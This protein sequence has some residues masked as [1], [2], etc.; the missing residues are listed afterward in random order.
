MLEE[1]C[2]AVEGAAK[3]GGVYPEVLFSVA[4]YW[5][6]LYEARTRH[7]ARTG[8]GRRGLHQDG[9]DL[10]LPPPPLSLEQQIAQPP[11]GPPMDSK[12]PIH[13]PVPVN[14][15]APPGPPAGPMPAYPLVTAAPSMQYGLT[16]YPLAYNYIQGLSSSMPQ[17]PLQVSLFFYQFKLTDI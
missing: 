17:L 2:L 9:G 13:L 15:T 16:A 7:Q 12:T 14:V 4:N 3:G 6:E 11:Q 10:P 5:Y 8:I 1:A